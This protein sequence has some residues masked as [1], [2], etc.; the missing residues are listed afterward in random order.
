MYLFLE[1]GAVREERNTHQLPLARPQLDTWPATQAGALP[2]SNPSFPR[3]VLSPLS[4]HSQGI[5]II[6]K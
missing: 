5:H 1:R 6:F 4:L 3:P 2:A